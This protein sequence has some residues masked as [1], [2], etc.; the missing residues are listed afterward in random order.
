MSKLRPCLGSA[1]ALT[2]IMLLASSALAG[3][4]PRPAYHGVDHGAAVDCWDCHWFDAE[5]AFNAQHVSPMVIGAGG[6]AV[7]VTYT[8]NS[9][10]VNGGRTGICQVCHTRTKYWGASY[11]W[12]PPGFPAPHFAGENCLNCHPHW[13]P[14][15]LFRPQM[16]GPQSHATHLTDPKGPR[17]PDCSYC[18]YQGDYSRFLD[19]RTIDTTTICDVC[20][21]PNG[22]VDGVNDPVVGAK[23]NWLHGVYDKNQQLKAGKEHWCDGCH[24]GGTSQVKG[25]QAPNVLGDNSTWGYNVS[26]HGRDPQNYV[27][28]LDCH[29]AAYEHCDGNARTY[30]RSVWPANPSNYVPGYR[31]KAAMNIPKWNSFAATDYTL[32][33]SCHDSARLFDNSGIMMTNF[34]NDRST[35]FPSKNLHYLHLIQPPG[36][37]GVGPL[38][39]SDW[40]GSNTEGSGDSTASCP[41]CHNVHGS[42]TPEMT[43]HGELMGLGSHGLDF[44]WYKQ[45]GSTDTDAVMASRWGASDLNYGS[46]RI[47]IG[48]HG[49][50]SDR[51]FRVPF[52]VLVPNPG[53]P[54][55]EPLKNG[56][57]W[58]SDLANN[59]KTTFR[60][61]EAFRVHCVYYVCPSTPTPPYDIARKGTVNGAFT[62]NL[63][64]TTAN[65]QTEG[66]YEALWTKTVPQAATPGAATVKVTV[67]SAVGGTDYADPESCK[68]QVQ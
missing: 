30:D 13:Q 22:P 36:G 55:A 20:H 3:Y 25:V 12:Q 7:S 2:V 32:C 47:C 38:W 66:V 58:T 4:Y 46:N 67:R 28:C 49:H 6:N 60:R 24:D 50:Y 31:L 68:I 19:G 39:D 44:H 15:N 40:D 54:S 8:G 5:N 33:L 11:D 61:S 62:M 26:G 10:F 1:L 23:P 59:P 43:R 17:L 21:S 64:K 18:H 51:Y 37:L 63:E 41:A 27:R 35:Q 45:D 56:L 42:P 34:R 9:D 16:K 29:S 52:Q 57:V 65:G 48:C 14:E 53:Q